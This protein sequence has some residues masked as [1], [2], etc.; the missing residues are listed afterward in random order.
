MKRIFLISALM[1]AAVNI[2]A[3]NAQS[4]SQTASQAVSA[5]AS[6]A[7]REANNAAVRQAC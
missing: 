6:A 3:A 4:A 2:E 7:A 1:L 5:A